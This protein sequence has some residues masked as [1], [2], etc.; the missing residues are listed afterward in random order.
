MESTDDTIAITSNWHRALLSHPIPGA[1]GKH[2][3]L[4]S[5]CPQCGNP[6]GRATEACASCDARFTPS[7]V[8]P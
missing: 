7:P 5:H 1:H 4:H 6:V 8:A 3:S 2:D